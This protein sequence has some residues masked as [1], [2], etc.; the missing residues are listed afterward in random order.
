M[1]ASYSSNLSAGL[2]VSQGAASYT[3]SSAGTVRQGDLTGFKHIYFPFTGTLTAGGYYA[4]AQIMSSATTGATGP[5]RI[6]FL[7]LSVINNLTVGKVYASTVIGSAASYVG[8]WNQGVYSS[9]SNGLPAT[10]AISG[11]TNAVS[12]QRMHLQFDA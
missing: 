6:G 10:L 5:L 12:Q 9:S 1:Q 7:E 11:L 2:T 4:F 8:D 3:A